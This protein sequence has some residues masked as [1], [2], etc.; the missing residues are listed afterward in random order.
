L[1]CVCGFAHGKPSPWI[2]IVFAVSFSDTTDTTISVVRSSSQFLLE[3]WWVHICVRHVIFF[4]LSFSLLKKSRSFSS[5]SS[6]R[7]IRLNWTNSMLHFFMR[8]KKLRLLSLLLL[9]R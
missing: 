7:L 5:F 8:D 3:P 1:P 4:H 9:N 6:T 2:K